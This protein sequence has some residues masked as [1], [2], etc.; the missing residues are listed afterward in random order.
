M[1]GNHFLKIDLILAGGNHFFYCIRYFSR[2]FSS[3]LVETNFSVQKKKYYFL[4]KTDFSASGN[5]YSNYTE[6]YL[7]LLSLL[8]ATICFDFI[9]IS[10]NVSSF[11]VSSK[12]VS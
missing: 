11:I 3:Q 5:Y 12:N 7:K 8:L 2:S 6:A 1:S 4:L 10:A 9:D